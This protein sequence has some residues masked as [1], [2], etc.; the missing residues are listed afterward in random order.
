MMPLHCVRCGTSRD[1]YQNNMERC[2]A[3][4]QTYWVSSPMPSACEVG[5][6]ALHHELS[7]MHTTCSCY[8]AVAATGR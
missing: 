7:G 5:V 6:M 2:A 8:T 3:W 4:Q 1:T